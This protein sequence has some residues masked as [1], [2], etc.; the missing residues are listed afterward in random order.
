MHQNRQLGHLSV[1]GRVA[2]GAGDA[3]GGGLK[4]LS[5]ATR[6]SEMSLRAAAVAAF[7]NAQDLH[8]EGALLFERERYARA[9]A[10]ALIGA[11]EFA[12][13]IIWTAAALMPPQ[14]P[15]LPSRLDGHAL[16][17]YVCGLADGA[18]AENDDGWTAIGYPQ[19]PSA[20]LIDLFIP[21]C[22]W[23]LA[24][25]LD[26]KVAQGHYRDLRR[27]HSEES[28][29]WAHLRAD[30]NRDIFLLTREPDLKNAALYVDLSSSGTVQSPHSRVD[31]RD[32][33]VSLRGLRYFLANYGPIPE[34]LGDDS[35]WATLA[36]EVRTRIP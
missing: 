35:L 1:V 4:G 30:P 22:R 3:G 36:S 29:R 14:R 34:V 18:V 28:K 11:E 10:L 32:A 13:S 16:K 27:Q 12:K 2:E 7:R 25:L 17:H 8:D 9:T 23:G 5:A 24:T 6:P 33:D 31:N 20:W 26:A 15:L 21:L 19:T